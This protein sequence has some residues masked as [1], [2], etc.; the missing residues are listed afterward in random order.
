MSTLATQLSQIDPTPDE[1]AWDVAKLFPPQGRWTPGEY[2]A[3]T[4]DS[5][6]LVEFVDGS[7]EVLEMPSVSHQLLVQFLSL[8]IHT[9]VSAHKLGVVLSAPLRVRLLDREFREPDV[10]YKHAA[11][12]DRSE[13]RFWNGADLVVE[14]VSKG[15]E[16][17]HRDLVRKRAA[18][19][20]AGIQEYWIVD[21]ESRSIVVLVLEP[22]RTYA[23]LG[24]F[25]PGTSLTSRVLPGFTLE[26][27]SVF[28]AAE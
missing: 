18:Y 25:S 12:I 24:A 3:L 13:D 23:E 9:F 5:N 2:L 6:H 26:V 20:A 7:I 1:P 11:S 15:K 22:H 21:P 10:V 17:R 14:V 8:A 27:A 19:A 4:D 16:A 28:A